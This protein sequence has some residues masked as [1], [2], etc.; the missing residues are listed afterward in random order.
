M[1]ERKI[2]DA[3]KILHKLYIE[4]KTAPR[5]EVLQCEREIAA[6]ERKV[7]ALDAENARLKVDYAKLLTRLGA[8]VEEARGFVEL[9]LCDAAEINFL[10]QEARALVEKWEA[11]KED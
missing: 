10:K 7:Y 9:V 5:E 2:T 1:G 11:K 6:L 4:G 8:Q 3:V